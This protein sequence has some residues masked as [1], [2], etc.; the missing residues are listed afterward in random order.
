MA[1]LQSLADLLGG[2]PAADAASITTD[3]HPSEREPERDEY[4]V[5]LDVSD[6]KDFC[7]KLCASRMFR[8][9]I[10]NSIILGDLPPAIA[11]RVV[12][13]G[14]G[15][16]PD[17]IEHTGKDGQPIETVTEVRRVIVRSHSQD[18]DIEERQPE[19]TH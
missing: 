14:I 15:K 5:L 8:R 12:D 10:L 19:R 6:P 2:T 16:T 9:Y 1:K 7:R 11:L 17:R 13:H 3:Q 18:F 4:D